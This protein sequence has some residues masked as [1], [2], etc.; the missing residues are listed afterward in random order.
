MIFAHS[1]HGICVQK[2]TE[3]L[4]FSEERATLVIAL[5]SACSTSGLDLP[6][7]SHSLSQPEGIPLYPIDM[8]LLSFTIIDPTCSFLAVDNCAN[9]SAQSINANLNFS[10]MR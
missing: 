5:A 8:I 6:K 9:L 2:I 1:I 10:F 7:C 4:Q 3:S